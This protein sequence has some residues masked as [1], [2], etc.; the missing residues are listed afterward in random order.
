[1]VHLGTRRDVSVLCL[2]LTIAIHFRG[3]ECLCTIDCGQS[4]GDV[5]EGRCEFQVEEELP[6]ETVIISLQFSED[7]CDNPTLNLNDEGNTYLKITGTNISMRTKFDYDANPGQ[8]VDRF[9]AEVQCNSISCSG[10][11]LAIK[12]IN[13][14]DNPITMELANRTAQVVELIPHN[15]DE[16]IEVT[17]PINATDFDVASYLSYSIAE[18]KSNFELLKDADSRQAAC[19]PTYGDDAGINPVLVVKE[20]GMSFNYVENSTFKLTVLVQSFME[21]NGCTEGAVENITVPLTIYVQDLDDQPPTFNDTVYYCKVEEESL[22]FL[23]APNIYAFDQDEGIDAPISYSLEQGGEWDCSS[24]VEIGESSGIVSVLKEFDFEEHEVCQLTL[25]ATQKDNHRRTATASLEIGIL[26]VNDVCPEIEVTSKQGTYIEGDNFVSDDTSQD[27]LLLK[28]TDADPILNFTEVEIDSAFFDLQSTSCDGVC[29]RISP[30]KT[31]FEDL[32]SENITVSVKDTL[33]NS[34]SCQFPVT[35]EISIPEDTEILNP[36][37]T[38]P[39]YSS[40]FDEN[41]TGYLVKV[42]ALNGDGTDEGIEYSLPDPE[43]VYFSINETGHIHVVVGLDYETKSTYFVTVKAIDGRWTDIERSSTVE[44]TII[45]IDVN[46]NV[47][48]LEG[49]PLFLYVSEGTPPNSVISTLQATD[50]DAGSNLTYKFEATP[51]TF[52]FTLNN[53]TG[54][55]STSG[56]LDADAENGRQYNATVVVSDGQTTTEP[57]DLVITILDVNDNPPI[58][59][60]DTQFMLDISENDVGPTILLINVTDGDYLEENKDYILSS[61]GGSNVTIDQKTGEVSVFGPFDR[62]VM[63]EFRFT[64]TVNNTASPSW[65]TSENVVVNI[66]DENDEEPTFTYETKLYCSHLTVTEETIPLEPLCTFS[67]TDDDEIGSENAEI[68]YIVDDEGYSD[69]FKMN[70]VTGELT[71]TRTFDREDLSNVSITV[72]ASDNGDN[73]NLDSMV[74]NVDI[75][76]VNDNRPYFN[77][78]G[79]YSTTVHEET[80]PNTLILNITAKDIDVPFPD[81]IYYRPA[82]ET[83]QVWETFYLKSE[84]GKCEIYSKSVLNAAESPYELT[85]ETYD[86]DRSPLYT[87]PDNRTIVIVAVEPRIA[88][89]ISIDEEYTESTRENDLSNSETVVDV[90][91]SSSCRESEDGIVFSIGDQILRPVEGGE[92]ESTFFIINPESGEIYAEDVT[93]VEIGMYVL[94][95][96]AKNETGS[97]LDQNEDSVQVY[98]NVTDVNN[99]CPYFEQTNYLARYTEGDRFLSSFTS[100]EWLVVTTIDDDTT[101]TGEVTFSDD[102]TFAENTTELSSKRSFIIAVIDG[103]STDTILNINVSDSTSIVFCEPSFTTINITVEE[104]L[105]PVFL[106]ESYSTSLPEN[107]QVGHPVIQVTA[108]NADGSMEDISYAIESPLNTPFMIDIESGEIV[109]AFGGIDYETVKDYNLTV[110]ATDNR[111][112]VARSAVTQVLIKIEDVNEFKPELLGLPASISVQESVEI[113]SEVFL[114]KGSDGDT[115]DNDNLTYK[116]ISGGEKKFAVN[117]NSGSVY[118]IDTIDFEK[119]ER[120]YTLNVSVSDGKFESFSELAIKIRDVND[121][122]PRFIQTSF[123]ENITENQS[124]SYVYAG[125][126]DDDEMDTVSYTL[127]ENYPNDASV[128]ETGFV[129]FTTIFDREGQE[130]YFFVVTASDGT[131]KT[132][133][134]IEIR[135][136]DENDEYP[137]FVSLCDG[138]VDIKENQPVNSL[139]CNISAE[140]ADAPGSTYSLITYSLLDNDGGPFDI[141]PS[142]GEI[143]LTEPLDYETNQ[144]FTLIVQAGDGMDGSENK[145]N[146]S[147]EVFVLD[148]N[149]NPPIFE[150][151]PSTIS[152]IFDLPVGSEVTKLLV[153]DD[154]EPPYDSFRCEKTDS[155]DASWDTF[156]V[157]TMKD[158]CSVMLGTSLNTSIEYTIRVTAV[159]FNN[160]SLTNSTQFVAVVSN[161]YPCE[162]TLEVEDVLLEKTEVASGDIVADVQAKSNCSD[163]EDGIIFTILSQQFTSPLGDKNELSEEFKISETN[164]TIFYAGSAEYPSVGEHLLVVEAVNGSDDAVRAQTQLLITIEDVDVSEP[165][166]PDPPQIPDNPDPSSTSVFVGRFDEG[167]EYVF[168]Y[169]DTRKLVITASDNDTCFSGNVK[170]FN[171]S[172]T[173]FYLEEQS[174]GLCVESFEA[175]L[176]VN[177]TVQDIPDITT[178]QIILFDGGN[179][180]TG[181]G[182]VTVARVPLSPVFQESPMAAVMENADVGDNVTKVFALN[183]DGTVDGIQYEIEP[184]ATYFE[185][186]DAE[187]GIITVKSIGIDYESSDF[188]NI[189]LSAHDTRWSPWRTTSTTVGVSVLDENEFKPELFPFPSISIQENVALAGTTIY[190]IQAYDSDASS[191]LQYYLVNNTETF[192]VNVESGD[193]KLVSSIDAETDPLTYYVNINVTDGIHVDSDVLTVKITDF[194]EFPPNITGESVVEMYENDTSAMLQVTAI[195]PDISRLSIVYS[196]DPSN[197]IASIDDNGEITFQGGLN[198]AEQSSYIFVVTAEEEG[199]EGLFSSTFE[200]TLVVLDINDHEPELGLD[201]CPTQNEVLEGPDSVSTLICTL[202]ASDQDAEMDT[203]F[204]FLLLNS[205][206]DTFHLDAKTGKLTVIAEL[207]RETEEDYTLEVL[208]N[209]GGNPSRNSSISTIT[210]KVGDA[211]DNPPEFVS[212]P[213]IPISIAEGSEAGTIV[214]QLTVMDADAFPYN[215]SRCERTDPTDT[216]WNNF[217]ILNDRV[218]YCDIITIAVLSDRLAYTL[219]VTAIDLNQEDQSNSVSLRV[220]V[221]A[222]DDCQLTIN[223]DSPLEFDEDQIVPGSEVTTVNASSLCSGSSDDIAFEIIEQ[224]LQHPNGNKEDVSVFEIDETGLISVIPSANVSLGQY[225]LIVTAYN[226]SMPI[227]RDTDELVIVI[228]DINN[229]CPAFLLDEDDGIYAQNDTF[230]YDAES[231][232][233]LVIVADDP[234]LEFIGTF[235]VDSTDV[236][237]V[238]NEISGGTLELQLSI[239][240]TFSGNVTLQVTLVDASISCLSDVITIYIYEIPVQ[241]LSPIFLDPAPFSGLVWEN[242]IAD[243]NITQVRAVDYK[244]DS[245]GITYKFAEEDS[246]I[247]IDPNSGVIT[248]GDRGLDYETENKYLKLVQASDGN[249]DPP[250]KSEVY[251]IIEV[252]DVDEYPLELAQIPFLNVPENSP[253]DTLVYK[254]S[255]TDADGSSNLTFSLEDSMNKFYIDAQSGEIHTMSNLDAEVSDNYNITVT[256]TEESS[257]QSESQNV[258]VFI[259]DVNDLPPE[260]DTNE[261]SEEVPENFEGVQWFMVYATDDDLTSENNI[262]SYSPQDIEDNRFSIDTKGNVTIDTNGNPFNREDRGLYEFRVI[263]RDNGNPAL[264]DSARVIVTVSDV[265]EKPVFLDS[266]PKQVNFAEG[267]TGPIETFQATDNDEGVNG[268]IVYSVEAVESKS[269][270]FFDINDDGELSATQELDREEVEI[271]LLNIYA[272]D[273]GAPPLNTSISVTVNVLDVNDNAPIFQP[274][275]ETIVDLSL[276]VGSEIFR[277]SATDDDEYP[278]DVIIFTPGNSSSDVWTIFT[279]QAN[280][281]KLSCLCLMK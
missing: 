115:D 247:K 175:Y 93:N 188:H 113:D 215:I 122:A 224:T 35:I 208:V 265:N 273:S 57:E 16:P 160:D 252:L 27:W 18:N 46:D 99:K 281:G 42:T 203:T 197:S 274:P 270:G 178:F 179:I 137:K 116:L 94:T 111:W 98:I 117:P 145:V 198:Y 165:E 164:G 50:R 22:E 158:C 78:D 233:R 69:Y 176:R 17:P 49:F 260:F 194:N 206:G 143:F 204:T 13:I 250:R 79:D 211:N 181:I 235:T 120:E 223:I 156:Y 56:P 155:S 168:N 109:V 258:Q 71:L 280:D 149:D 119:D 76:G 157:T 20:N 163:S 189:S 110:S 62:E 45:V 95:I 214:A 268:D 222:D 243:T 38:L 146:G 48:V 195:D 264:S 125:A 277:I 14:D 272:T 36:N 186:K 75:V 227:S 97:E 24:Y 210:L 96:N 245:S 191:S 172:S 114:L 92:T 184:Q 153:S 242:A 173:P 246:Y 279:L 61:N 68:T 185:L 231:S 108:Q 202:S 131:L 103:L 170:V 60:S 251:V 230:I 59:N 248:T 126:T 229:N 169:I 3:A 65:E 47:P 51:D 236:E 104:Y 150:N 128:N 196:I 226:T 166:F 83:D 11:R 140:D 133:A 123:Y 144:R 81:P 101:F 256:V 33:Y 70:D 249:W 19:F 66:L 6:A 261:Y 257:S 213:T 134:V 129:K 8:I 212:L 159:D 91:A 52:P 127:S 225:T 271:H 234:D 253:N 187:S 88:C 89:N 23:E 238:E 55:I 121:N 205:Y 43:D 263:A 5:K 32:E 29:F 73:P 53:D 161:T 34:T 39:E 25:T 228:N 237:V 190:K 10:G 26:N 142:K 254:A 7:H 37:F 30:N 275:F 67:A 201:D 216:V 82:D 130:Y 219:E 221:I 199:D 74:V 217:T 174:S 167:D 63:S 262:I 2:V 54:E 4:G 200:V 21:D 84:N 276:P 1:M 241:E 147:L 255:A 112:D 102:T 9:F 100:P 85:I 15:S 124:P 12:F 86:G 259:S 41:R 183:N 118:T 138:N 244:G 193:V 135:V 58:M 72:V 209:D 77:P 232:D 64:L 192:E 278:N 31:N 136:L 171:P 240:S 266:L 106:N 177:D 87:G 267:M 90:N 105:S 151:H 44:V 182:N 132:S 207:D 152:V 162:I 107:P 40:E 148:T 80:T 269:K 220:Q 239:A 139:V 154:D 218:G 141:N 180:E 28:L